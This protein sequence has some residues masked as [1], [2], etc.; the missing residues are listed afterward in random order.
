MPAEDEELFGGEYK[1]GDGRAIRR[2]ISDELTR[3][4]Q[5][6]LQNVQKHKTGSKA[7][8]QGFPRRNGQE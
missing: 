1:R 6:Q 5:E 3:Y 8:L 2:K 4:V 7:N